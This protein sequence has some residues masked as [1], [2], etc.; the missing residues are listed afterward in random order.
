MEPQ[1][2]GCLQS[3]VTDKLPVALSPGSDSRRAPWQG[4]PWRV[5]EVG[6]RGQ[7]NA[8][9]VGEGTYSPEQISPLMLALI[10]SRGC[11]LSLPSLEEAAR[12]TEGCCSP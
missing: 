10:Q 8:L 3:R 2:H 11:L 4:K 7:D 9:T 5:W 12:G 1:Q 6:W